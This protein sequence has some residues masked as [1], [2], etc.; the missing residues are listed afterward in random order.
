MF[1]HKDL[2]GL[3]DC[4]AEEIT[5][6]LDAADKMRE[7]LNGKKKK[8]DLL[9]GKTLVTLFYEN[10]TRTRTSFELAGKYL[11][12]NE[13]NISVAASSVQ[14]GET[15]IDTGRTLDDMKIDFIAIRHSMAGA[16]KLLAENVK[17]S[18]LNGGD[19]INEHP[20]QALLDMLTLRRKFGKIKGL[21]VA[22]LGDIKHSRVAK[23]NIFGLKKL[24]AEIWVYAPETLMPR[25]IEKLGAKKASSRE[26]AIDGADGVMGLRIQLERQSGGLF[27]SLGEYSKFYGVNENLMKYAKK[28]AVILHPGPVNRGVELTPALIDGKSSCINEQVTCGLAVRMAVLKLLAEYRGKNL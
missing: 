11:G 15:L 20:T 3:Q 5:E 26:Q 2:L 23:S 19:G 9:A 16:P 6:I 10:S 28:D 8:P 12:A 1:R 4:T 24:G 27:P 21:K 22:I 13:V 18:V 7:L 14:K 17:A 25:E